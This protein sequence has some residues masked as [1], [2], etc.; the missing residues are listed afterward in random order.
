MFWYSVLLIVYVAHWLR[1]K[2]LIEFR[3]HP[4]TSGGQ[5][6]ELGMGKN[7][8]LCVC[9]NV[10]TEEQSQ[11]QL[12]LLRNQNN[13]S[14]QVFLNDADTSSSQQA[15]IHQQRIE[16]LL[17][18]PFHGRKTNVELSKNETKQT[19]PPQKKLSGQISHISFPLQAILAKKGPGTGRVPAPQE[20]RV[21]ALSKAERKYSACMENDPYK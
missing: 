20:K 11:G 21:T 9:F 1:R 18:N 19:V 10:L 7:K 4:V 17:I 16:I 12:M 6:A 5:R 14:D 13:Y 3:P 8:M 15:V 2:C